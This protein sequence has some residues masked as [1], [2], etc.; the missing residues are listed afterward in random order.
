MEYSQ[1]VFKFMKY[2]VIGFLLAFFAAIAGYIFSNPLVFGLCIRTYQFSDYIGC[3]DDSIETVGIP[4]F[5]FSLFTLPVTVALFFVSSSIFKS[6]SKFTLWW[7]PFSV[8]VVAITPANSNSWMSLYSFLK[9]DAAFLMGSLFMMLSIGIIAGK[10]LSVL[11]EKHEFN[12]NLILKAWLKFV[13]FWV[14]FSLA[15][16][17]MPILLHMFL[18]GYFF[19]FL[20]FPISVEYGAWFAGV[21]FVLI[22]LGIIA[23]KSFALR[24]KNSG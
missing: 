15:F 9:E 16:I 2:S 22:S 1:S 5:I 19:N 12:R 4:L 18:E 13:Y 3:A 11:F 17:L 7:I 23:W 10:W 6:W 8:F 20:G 14:P 21:L 24:K